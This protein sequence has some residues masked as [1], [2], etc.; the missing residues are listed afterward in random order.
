VGC[1][2][3]DDDRK[4]ASD[5]GLDWAGFVEGFFDEAEGFKTHEV[6]V[7]AQVLKQPA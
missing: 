5:E 3:D 4:G 1:A 7:L 6:W 2:I